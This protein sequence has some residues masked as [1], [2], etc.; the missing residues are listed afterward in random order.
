MIGKIKE[1]SLPVS[2]KSEG[3]R[4]FSDPSG[5]F[6]GW[7]QFWGT[8][9]DAKAPNNFERSLVPLYSQAPRWI[10]LGGMYGLLVGED[11]GYVLPGTPFKLSGDEQGTGR[12]LFR[13]AALS[14]G[15]I[16]AV[17]FSGGEAAPPGGAQETAD[18]PTGT[19][20]LD[21][22]FRGDALI[23]RIAS[24]DASREES[25][26]L[27]DEAKG[28][29][30]VILEFAIAQ[31]HFDAELRLD[32]PAGTTGL[33]SIALAAPV[34]GEGIVRLGGAEPGRY[35]QGVNQQ[36]LD[37]AGKHGAGTMALKELA[38]SYTRLPIPRKEEEFE[39]RVSESLTVEEDD[40]NAE[41]ELSS[42]NTF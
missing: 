26:E 1:L 22:F 7:Y 4:Y 24:N 12:I 2:L 11:A 41:P 31:D 9:D 6:I 27:G 34:S 19:A 32:D 33:L 29:I 15:A 20:E 40:L 42:L 30:T 10:P 35:G 23:L 18:R 38:L 5:E 28:F 39:S 13:L 21:L 25:L 17:R 8:L 36:A 37:K 16:A 3:I 14:E